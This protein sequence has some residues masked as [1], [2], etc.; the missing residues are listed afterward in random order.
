MSQV[1]F[2]N[3][4]TSVVCSQAHTDLALSA[5]Q[6]GIVLLKNQGALPLSAAAIK[7]LAVI[8]PNGEWALAT[9]CV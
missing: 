3:V 2:S 5:A 1:P 9:C 7:T 4:P 6:Q 8:G